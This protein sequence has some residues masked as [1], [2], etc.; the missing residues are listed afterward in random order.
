LNPSLSAARRTRSAEVGTRNERAER[1]LCDPR[2]GRDEN[3]SERSEVPLRVRTR[4]ELRDLLP[5]PAQPHPGMEAPPQSLPV[6]GETNAEGGQRVRRTRWPRLDRATPSRRVSLRA[7]SR[8]CTSRSI[9][10]TQLSSPKSPWTP[11]SSTPPT[12]SSE[13]P[14]LP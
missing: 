13:N 8:D 14:S 3:P 12:G 2:R 1:F 11:V 9:Q 5:D 7:I 6:R 10:Q 4:R